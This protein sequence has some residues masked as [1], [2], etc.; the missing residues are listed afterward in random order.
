[1]YLKEMRVS[2]N[3]RRSLFYFPFFSEV[4]KV[5]V[6]GKR[7]WSVSHCPCLSFLLQTLLLS[8]VGDKVWRYSGFKLDQGYPKQLIIPPNIEA[9]FYSKADKKIIF[10]KVNQ[11]QITKA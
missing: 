4:I 7:H 11:A 6:A 1:M 9:A 2:K 8:L 3:E 5:K 10:I